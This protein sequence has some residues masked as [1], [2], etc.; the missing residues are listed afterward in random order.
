MDHNADETDA[1]FTGEA[2][3]VSPTRSTATTV[4]PA[5]PSTL[6]PMTIKKLYDGFLE[7]IERYPIVVD[8]DTVSS[9]I[10]IGT[11]SHSTVRMN[12]WSFDLQ[13]ATGPETTSDFKLA[14]SSSNGDYVQ[15]FGK[16]AMNDRFLQI[17]A[18][19]IR[20]IENYNDTTHH[21]LY[22]IHTTLDIRKRNTHKARMEPDSTSSTVFP[23]GPSITP[24]E[25]PLH[26]STKDKI[27]AILRD[28][29]YR[30]IQ[31][32]VSLKVI[33][34]A[35]DISQDEIMQVITEQIYI[36]MIYTTVDDNHFKSSI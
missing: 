30:D 17:K 3:M 13:D 22:T 29:A 21:Y 10:L 32:G 28:P 9:V 2:M 19:K 35:L 23:K 31:H 34:S 25:V 20:L 33:R 18:F 8:G 5:H 6:R 26:S 24:S 15:L 36:G 4:I 16:P 12:H 11:V 27:F 7:D 1:L 14:W